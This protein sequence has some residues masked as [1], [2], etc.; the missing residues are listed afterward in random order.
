MNMRLATRT[1]HM[2]VTKKAYRILVVTLKGTDCLGNTS[3]GGRLVLERIL[4]T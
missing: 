1:P 4:L 2:E 3:V